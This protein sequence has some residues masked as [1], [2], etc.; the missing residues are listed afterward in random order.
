MSLHPPYRERAEAWLAED[1]DPVTAHEL[2]TLIA[3]ADGGDA[4]AI[5]DLHERFH[6]QLE[7]GTAG[8]RGVLGAGPQRMNRVLVRKVAAGLC[9]YLLEHVPDARTRGVLVGHDA[10]T[11]SREFSEDTARILAG[12][13]IRAYL[14]HRP[15]PTPPPRGRSP[16]A[17]R[18]RA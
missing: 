12:V 4:A 9:A 6:G 3:K 15:W 8:L 5:R 10:R 11:N 14:A 2:R 1:Q 16:I 18:A 17:T 13:G 7:F